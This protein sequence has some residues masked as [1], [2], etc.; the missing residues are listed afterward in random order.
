[1]FNKLKYAVTVLKTRGV[2][3]LFDY[4]IQAIWFDIKN[5]TTTSSRVTKDQQNISAQEKDKDDGL[6][7]VAS[8]TNVVKSSLLSAK[9]ILGEKEFFDAQFIDL[10]CG[11]GKTLMVYEQTYGQTAQ[12]KAVGIE[13]DLE[14]S[15]QAIENLEKCKISKDRI[16]VFCDTATN[17]L[18][19]AEGEVLIVYLYNSFQGETLRTVLKI[20]SDIPHILIYVDPA[21]KEVLNDYGYDVKVNTVGKYNATTWLVATSEKL[22]SR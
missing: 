3:F 21:E 14:L 8:F 15:K 19:Y 7:Y 4:F 17:I 10:G 12:K 11:K 20:M 9:K 2:V 5:G 18:S 6:L 1:M 13:Y 16:E 22:N